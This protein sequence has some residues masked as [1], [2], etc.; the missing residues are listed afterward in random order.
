M[1]ISRGKLESVLTSLGTVHFLCKM[2]GAIQ[3]SEAPVRV[4]K[5]DD[6]GDAVLFPSSIVDEG[7]KDEF[8]L[9]VR[10]RYRGYSDQDG[11]EGQE[12]GVETNFGNHGECLAKAVEEEAEDVG[13]LVGNEDVP[14]LDG[15]E[16]NQSV[17]VA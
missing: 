5:S 1:L 6:E 15:A 3:A 11:E 14:W 7:S 4:D 16:D 17:G 12:R 13:H 9:L 8:G 10:G 2:C